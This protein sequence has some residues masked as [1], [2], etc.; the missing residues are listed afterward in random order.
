MRVC[1]TGFAGF[2]GRHLTKRCVDM[3]Y[4]VVGVDDYSTGKR[5]VGTHP[6][7]SVYEMDVRQ[8]FHTQQAST[9]DL[10][11][12]CAAVVGGRKMID[13]A[14]LHVATDLSIDAEFFNWCCAQKEK[15][16]RVVYFSS[17]AV[18]PVELQTERLHTQLNEALTNF[19]GTRIPMPDQTYGWSKLTGEYLMQIAVKQYGLECVCYRPFSGYGEDQDF[20]YPF[21]SIIRRV[22][23][24][25]SP[26]HVWGTG[27]QTRDFIHI[28]DVVNA[29]FESCVK[30][31][32][33]ETIN[34]GTGIPTSFRDLISTARTVLNH[35]AKIKALPG[36]PTGVFYRVADTY[37]M[38]KYYV[39]QISLEE[40]V[41]RVHDYLEAEGLLTSVIEKV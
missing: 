36:E 6:K 19:Q 3:G 29:V 15:P 23:R 7:V 28:D 39:P 35:S 5:L 13:G 27:H 22:G 14:P 26:I 21:P 10:V 41:K 9:F 30:M 12:H 17:S 4:D 25:E 32:P 2:V 11:F 20:S 34:L 16:R 8:F 1:I 31:Q 24:R 40:G 37:K 38:R 18:Y 33:G